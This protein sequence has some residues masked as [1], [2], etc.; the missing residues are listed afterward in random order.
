M[1]F[2]ILMKRAAIMLMGVALVLAVDSC[3]EALTTL[4][5]D[6]TY[7]VK[8]RDTPPVLGED[9]SGGQA[10]D[11]LGIYA[12]E[13]GFVC[14]IMNDEGEI[15]APNEQYEHILEADKQ[16]TIYSYYIWHGE[17][18]GDILHDAKVYVEFPT[19]ISDD[20]HS[21]LIFHFDNDRTPLNMAAWVRS[22]WGDLTVQTSEAAAIL[23]DVVHT[24]A[25]D[26]FTVQELLSSNCQVKLGN[27]GGALDGNLLYQEAALEGQI[28][29]GMI[30]LSYG[31]ATEGAPIVTLVMFI[32]T[33]PV[34]TVSPLI[35]TGLVILLMGG[36]FLGVYFWQRKRKIVVPLQPNKPRK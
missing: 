9:V 12:G 20:V 34:D 19:T 16:Y 33:A 4:A 8:T 23:S 2:N 17:H 36:L 29:D 35:V 6:A 31:A 3:S 28:R 1:K 26:T 5:A 18:D 24:A 25:E 21:E 10:L 32:K 27:C 11:N 13:T 14:I 22:E 15:V 30:D 7:L